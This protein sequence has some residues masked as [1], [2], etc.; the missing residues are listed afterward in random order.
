[1]MAYSDFPI[2]NTVADYPSYIQV[3][4]YLLNYAKHF[5]LIDHIM[6]NTEVISVRKKENKWHVIY[7]NNDIE[8]EDEYDGIVVANGHYSIPK[9]PEELAELKNTYKRGQVIHSK[10][11]KSVEIF[12]GKSVLVVGVAS[13]G[14][15]ICARIAAVAEKTYVSCRKSNLV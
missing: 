12:S 9:I 5:Q 10:D 6:L 14:A 13:S 2:L 11:F 15:E 4:E 7:K 3:Y 1:M 8:Y